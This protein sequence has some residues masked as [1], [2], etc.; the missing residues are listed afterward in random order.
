MTNAPKKIAF[1]ANTARSFLLFR[2]DLIRHYVRQGHKVV[3]LAPQDGTAGEDITA[4][5]AEYRPIPLTRSGLNPLQ[6]ITSFKNLYRELSAIRPDFIVSYTIKPNT[7]VPVVA[8]LL[9]VPCLAVVTGLGYAFMS[10][11]LKAKVAAKIFLTGLKRADTV[12]FLNETDRA[13]L[14]K[15]SPSLQSRSGILQGEGV[16]PSFYA[17]MPRQEYPKTIFLMIARLL[18]DKG[19]LEYA[20]AAKNINA[21]RNDV[22]FR[23]LG[24]LDAGN[25]TGLSASEWDTILQEGNLTYMGSCNDVRPHIA[26]ADCIVLPSYR[27]GIS[28]ALLEGASMARPMVA[29]DVPG[30]REIVKDD[31]NGYLC[32]AIDEVS[33]QE[34]L[35]KFL[36]LADTQ[37][38]NMGRNARQTV[39]DQFSTEVIL[40][41]YDDLILKS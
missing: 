29:T 33:L 1:V 25:P 24:D 38:E 2:A 23:V 16:D 10:S 14:T 35:E 40:K 34:S 41:Q 9:D 13:A 37:K 11:S 28:R 21:K 39:I 12:W 6:E 8:S 4:M 3:C 36:C 27:E 31:Y 15:I 18:K 30:C 7:Y 5:G 19:I 22:E 26:N 32:K 20:A 17:P